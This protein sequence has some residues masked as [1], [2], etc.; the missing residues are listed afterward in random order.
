M[1]HVEKMEVDDFPFAVQLANTMNW[2]M[3]TE[4]FEFMKKLEPDGCFVLFHDKKRLGIATS[5]S[6]G[7]AGWFGNLVVKEQFRSEGAGNLLTEHALDYLRIKGVETIGLYAY[8]H[9]VNFYERFGFESDIDFA[10]LKG[11]VTFS[12]TQ[13]R[14][15]EPRKRDVPEIIDFDRQWYGANRQKLLEAILLS[16]KN[17]CYISTENNK[18][19]GYI[20]AKVYGKTAEIGP[21]ICPPN[22]EEG[23][24]L[25]L[26]NI[27]SRLNGIEVFIY[28]P[29][30]MAELLKMLT[31]A[32]FKENFRVV[33]MFLGSG[34]AQNCICTA[35]SL[36]RG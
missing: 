16:S 36:E 25:L 7:K 24:V 23:A 21:L 31:K 29:R 9:L 12:S 8:P 20:A 1:F 27:L 13:D 3:T 26:A 35:E 18:I 32:G 17:F 22:H 2:N 6:F 15:K 5:V 30:K 4:D 34:V 33:R 14:L 10:V 19:T 11:K 28:I